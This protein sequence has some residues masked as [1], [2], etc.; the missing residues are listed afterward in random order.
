MYFYLFLW[1]MSQLRFLIIS[2]PPGSM[3]S[4][5]VADLFL[6]PEVSFEASFN[7][8]YKIGKIQHS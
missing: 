3:P 5:S 6:S 2:C 8:K 4:G 1:R 7:N